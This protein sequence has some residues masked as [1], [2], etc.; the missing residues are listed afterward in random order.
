MEGWIKIHRSIIDKGWAS[1][2]EYLALWLHLLLFATHRVREV[3]WNGSIYHLQPGE[4]ITG[5]NALSSQTGINPSKVERILKLFK[6][7]QQIEQRMT[8]TSRLIS[9][10]NWSKYQMSEQQSE[11]RV[12]SEWTAS[13]QRLNTKQECKK[14]K[15][16]KNERKESVRFTPPQRID[17]IDYFSTLSGQINQAERFYDYYTANGWKAGRN[18]M[19][20]WKAAARNWIRKDK[21]LNQDKTKRNATASIQDIANSIEQ[22]K[23]LTITPINFDRHEPPEI[24]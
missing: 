13:E 15:N 3:L 17:V 16:I 1:D 24:T 5:R 2:P 22:A 12:N 8:S 9:I 21:E 18:P 14:D 6:S 11:Q 10:L 23:R 20:D 4:F 19:K 7:E